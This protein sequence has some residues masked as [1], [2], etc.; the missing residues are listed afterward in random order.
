MW[1]CIYVSICL[2]MCVFEFMYACV[3][4]KVYLYVY[5]ICVYVCMC[6]NVCVLVCGKFI[7]EG[8]LLTHPM[9]YN[10]YHTPLFQ[11]LKI[12]DRLFIFDVT[13]L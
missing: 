2:S 12:N 4:G 6:V 10:S 8:L 11:S 7:K 1:V 5:D 3:S 9:N 13:I